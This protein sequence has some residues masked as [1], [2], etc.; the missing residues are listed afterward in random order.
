MW[1]M[2]M[3]FDPRRMLIGIHIFL[4][5]LALLIHFVLLSTAR[6]N[7][8]DDGSAA[9]SSVPSAVETTLLG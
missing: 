9:M 5:I 8:F 1:K 7:W 3:M 4:F 6:Y 2:W